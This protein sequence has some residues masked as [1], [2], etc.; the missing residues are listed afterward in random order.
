MTDYLQTLLSRLTG[1]LQT[2]L[3]SGV[4]MLPNFILAVGVVT[5]A[6][7][8]SRV[9]DRWTCRALD[10][11][12]D[13]RQIS[14]LL[15]T[16]ARVVVVIVGLFFALGLLHLDK[17]VTS[18]LAGVGV[19]GLALGFAFQD[20]AANLMSGLFM[21][22]RG[23]FKVGDVI[24]VAGHLGTVERIELRATTMRTFQGLT[25]VLP[26]KDVFQNDLI[27]YTRTD[28][29]RVDIPVGVAYS[30]DLEKAIEA[31]VEGVSRVEARD[32]DRPIQAFYSD[33]GDSSINLIVHVWMDMANQPD[34]LRTRSEAIMA[35]K[36]AV[37]EAGL[38]IPFPIRTLDFGAG[39]VG[40]EALGQQPLSVVES[41][42]KSA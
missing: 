3:E 8:L 41:H 37:D 2:W 22:F 40:G 28:E 33:F 32:M 15:G 17:T 21:A 26:N 13:N 12:T 29:R 39:V 42:Q 23:H 24:E 25:V 36:K 14:R 38:T 35:I 20:I 16:L 34:F 7:L 4:E 27:N 18:L 10:R 6:G 1:K 30:D 11:W 9:I 5:I 31:I 19:I